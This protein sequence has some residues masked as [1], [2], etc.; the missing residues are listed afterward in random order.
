[1]NLLMDEAAL[2]ISIASLEQQLSSLGSWQHG[3][4]ALVI[5]GCAGELIFVLYSYLNERK[6]W[7]GTRTRAVRELPE[8]PSAVVLIFE[9]LSVAAVVFGILGE[10]QVDRKSENIQTNLRKANGQLVLLLEKEAGAAKA[11]AEG[12][13]AAASHAQDIADAVLVRAETLEQEGKKVKNDLV[14]ASSRADL[15][16]SPNVSSNLLKATRPLAGQKVDVRYPAGLSNSEPQLT[17]N[18]LASVLRAA[19]M[20]VSG[21]MISKQ[22]PVTGVFV[23]ITWRASAKTRENALRLAHALIDL[24]LVV[25]S[26]RFEASAKGVITVPHIEPL[27]VMW[28]LKRD[29]QVFSPENQPLPFDDDTIVIQVCPHP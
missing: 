10:L 2:R 13:A 29:P 16:T 21:P 20:A 1:M 19:G 27:G 11:S 5:L 18:L 23:Y 14:L 12:A 25:R 3:W 15:F 28:E 24:P 6:L 8:K 26:T 7:R 22:D 4:T 9:L 17:A